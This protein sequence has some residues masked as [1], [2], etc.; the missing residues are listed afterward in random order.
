MTQA[1]SLTFHT[2]ID[3]PDDA[4]WIVLSNSLGSNLSM[5]DGQIPL[6]TRK[7]RVLRYDHR[8]HGQTEVPP[9]PYTWDQLTSDVIALMDAHGIEQADWLGLSMGGMTGTGLAVHH[10]HRFGRMVLADFRADAPP[11]YQSMWDQRIATITEQGL[12]AIADGILD[13]WLNPAWR[14]ANPSRLAALRETLT[15]TNPDGYIGCC[16]AIRTLDYL[17]DAHTITNPVLCLT[18]AD[19]PTA[20]P[21]TVR[22]IADT[23]PGAQYAELPGA[24]H[25]SNIDSEDAFNA[26]I[27]AFLN[28]P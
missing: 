23:I 8:G 4:P 19:D 27:A 5:W 24:R 18:G 10:G 7:Y 14:A 1:N 22:A 16:L 20:A 3:G 25:I 26:T 21:A 28:I 15:G 12:S 11:E 2:K 17:K 13:M 9:G 6:L